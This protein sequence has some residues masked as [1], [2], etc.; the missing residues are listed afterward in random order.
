MKLTALCTLMSFCLMAN[1][2]KVAV[3]ADV[4]E[5]A[6]S[7]QLSVG[8]DGK[9]WSGECLQEKP[10]NPLK[11][12]VDSAVGLEMKLI[13][14]N[15]GTFDALS[16]AKHSMESL[17]D[18]LERENLIRP[19]DKIVTNTV[20]TLLGLKSGLD[21]LKNSL[22]KQIN[23]KTQLFNSQNTTPDPTDVFQ[24]DKLIKGLEAVNTDSSAKLISQARADTA[25]KLIQ[26]INDARAVT[27]DNLAKRLED[28]RKEAEGGKLTVTDVEK[29]R[30]NLNSP[31]QFG[32]NGAATPQL[33]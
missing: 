3:V 4:D 17:K 20:T 32:I 8:C 21:D 28:A 25:D 14:G 22:E 2:S 10:I 19:D 24:G 12:K 15:P 27:G 5:Y 26:R 18:A 33:F 31:L 7:P 9:D 13:L 11:N 23:R 29:I 1:M 30:N 6:N 16:S